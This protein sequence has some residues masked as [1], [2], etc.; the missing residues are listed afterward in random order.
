MEKNWEY[1]NEK[2]KYIFFLFYK[3]LWNLVRLKV[4]YVSFCYSNEEDL[5]IYDFLF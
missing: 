1:V 5:V 2:K 4:E 3:G